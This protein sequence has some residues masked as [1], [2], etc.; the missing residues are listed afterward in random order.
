M[1]SPGPPSSPCIFQHV[2]ACYVVSSNSFIIIQ[3]MGIH[4]LEDVYAH[5]MLLMHDHNV[6]IVI[7]TCIDS[8]TALS[9][10]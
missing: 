4:Y 9:D 8:T 7:P 5:R 10:G 6:A 3:N 2:C 1:K